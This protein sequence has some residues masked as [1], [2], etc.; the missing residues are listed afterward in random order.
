MKT[1]LINY[2]MQQPMK[3][4]SYAEYMNLVLYHPQFGYYMRN[5]EKI[6]RERG[7]Y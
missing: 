3:M 4:I 2:I 1:F 5:E 6:G 7:F